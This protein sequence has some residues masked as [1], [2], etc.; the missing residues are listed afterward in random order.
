DWLHWGGQ[1]VL[2]GGAGPNFSIF[3]DSF[4]NRYLPAD[5]TGESQLLGESD[6]KP[7]SDAYPP[8][9]LPSLP[10]DRDQDK[11]GRRV[12]PEVY[13]PPGA[14]YRMPVPIQPPKTRPIFVAGSRA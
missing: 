9:V 1:L 11:D 7:L 14:P 10:P 8:T 12:Q 4:L 5:P 2:I 13:F 3:R 6:L